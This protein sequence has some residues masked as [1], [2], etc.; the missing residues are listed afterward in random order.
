M[1]R[2]EGFRITK[3]LLLKKNKKT[4][5]HL[6]SNSDMVMFG[7]GLHHPLDC[8]PLRLTWDGGYAK[9]PSTERCEEGRHLK[10]VKTYET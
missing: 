3:N 5:I 7:N 2:N 9:G 10:Y 8:L 6:F 4:M 1:P